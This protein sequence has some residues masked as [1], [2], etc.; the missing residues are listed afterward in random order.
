MT[1]ETNQE[2]EIITEEDLAPSAEELAAQEEAKQK[3]KE[4]ALAAAK[5]TKEKEVE[6]ARVAEEARQ[7]D[8]K[9]RYAGLHDHRMASAQ[10]AISN[11][12]LHFNQNILAEKDHN[13]A[14]AKI[15]ELEAKDQ[16]CYAGIQA[17]IHLDRRKEAYKEIDVLLLE[18][19]AEKEEGRPER[20]VEYLEK[21]AAIREANPKV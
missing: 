9:D 7:Q 5:I 10:L 1:E 11:P 18:A 17:T 21:R 12:D 2:E 20:M 3:A 16:E 13:V 4:A 14:E 19:L 15:L 8:L 6:A